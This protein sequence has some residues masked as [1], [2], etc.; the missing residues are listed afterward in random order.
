MDKYKYRNIVCK[1]GLYGPEVEY[2]EKGI[3][4]LVDWIYN[5]QTGVDIELGSF[6]TFYC[7]AFDSYDDALYTVVP[8]IQDVKDGV[9]KNYP[10][11]SIPI[12]IEDKIYNLANDIKD[13]II[14]IKGS[15]VSK[16]EIKNKI[17]DLI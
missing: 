10:D 7:D 9:Y 4:E 17:L 3:T 11:V 5:F 1:L 14:K 16:D 13:Y 12:D 15:V 2:V 6:L 8:F